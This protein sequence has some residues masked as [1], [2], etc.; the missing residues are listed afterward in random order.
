MKDLYKK[1]SIALGKPIVK[2]DITNVVINQPGV[3]SCVS[4]ELVN[5]AGVVK[6]KTYSTTMKNL[7]LALKD[8]IYFAEPYEIFELR[9][10][11]NDI[12]ITVL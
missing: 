4:V 10:P 9:H 7:D 2:S 11:E 3:I 12:M 6:N 8:D 5:V 1:E